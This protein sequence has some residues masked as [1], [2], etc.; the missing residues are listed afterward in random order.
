[1]QKNQSQS[2]RLRK[3][4]ERTGPHMRYRTKYSCDQF[5]QNIHHFNFM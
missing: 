4:D 2:N 1:M 3:I 5:N